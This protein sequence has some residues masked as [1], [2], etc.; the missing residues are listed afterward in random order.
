MNTASIIT[1][2]IAVFG[3]LFAL[4]KYFVSIEKR[5]TTVESEVKDLSKIEQNIGK[6]VEQGIRTEEK[7]KYIQE[8][9]DSVKAKMDKHLDDDAKH[10]QD[11]H[12]KINKL[13]DDIHREISAA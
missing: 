9:V 10:K 2:C 7:L 12:E 8:S 1:T 5:I 4:Y 6:L 3:V 11:I 13:K